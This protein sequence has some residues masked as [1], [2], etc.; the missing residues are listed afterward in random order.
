MK[1]LMKL[2]Y[3]W[4]PLLVWMALI[5]LASDQ[6]S[7]ELPDYGQWDLVVKK[8]GHFFG[9]AV[10]ALLARRAGLHPLAA[11]MLAGLYATT[12][13]WHQ[14]FVPG[15]NGSPVDVLIDVVGAIMGVLLWS[16]LPKGL[17]AQL[18]Q[19]GDADRRGLPSS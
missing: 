4:L 15:R 2:L 13:E 11:V 17:Q 1:K 3:R 8:S 6:P 9:Y 16:R 10:L 18:V 5:Y 19:R 14:S 12:D 7:G